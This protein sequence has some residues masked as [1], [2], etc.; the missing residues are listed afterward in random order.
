MNLCVGLDRGQM[1]RSGEAIAIW[2]QFASSIRLPFVCTNVVPR[3]CP[4][5]IT[6]VAASTFVQMG[7]T[8]FRGQEYAHIILFERFCDLGRND[9]LQ[10]DGALLSPA[11]RCWTFTPEDIPRPDELPPTDHRLSLPAR[12]KR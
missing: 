12:A 3:A 5:P 2:K 9:A 7:H 4:G 1:E 10:L 11:I 8:D 6:G